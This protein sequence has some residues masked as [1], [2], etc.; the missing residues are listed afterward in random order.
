MSTPANPLENKASI[1]ALVSLIRSNAQAIAAN[2]DNIA[3][4]R[5]AINATNAGINQLKESVQLLTASTDDAADEALTVEAM[6][7]TN[8]SRFENLLSEARADRAEWREAMARDRE[9][10]TRRFNEQMAEIR[11][12]GEQN[13]ALLSALATTN[14]R[15]DSLEQAS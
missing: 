7:T 9:E 4:T 14:G 6:A 13:R 12:L 1:N 3:A 5:E 8:E 10:S 11:A 2:S 15:V